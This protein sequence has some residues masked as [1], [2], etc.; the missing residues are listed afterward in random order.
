MTRHHTSPLGAELDAARVDGAADV[1][2]HATG[3]RSAVRA[4]RL[5]GSDRELAFRRA[6][7]E[8]FSDRDM[9]VDGG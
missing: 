1:V 4:T 6:V 2:A 9:E 8:M 3:R 5:P 7:E